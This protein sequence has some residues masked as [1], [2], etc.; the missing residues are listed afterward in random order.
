M[1][2][3]KSEAFLKTENADVLPKHIRFAVCR[4]F[5]RCGRAW[6][7]CVRRG[8]LHGPYH[9]V[10]YRE[11]GRLI[12]RYVKVADV[13]KTKVVGAARREEERRQREEQK[14][15]MQLFRE[16]SRYLRGFVNE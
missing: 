10:F 1:F 6:C 4:Q 9:Y 2:A 11:R 13:D 15:A 5:V 3:S 14:Q 16:Y 8:E 12:K 7:K